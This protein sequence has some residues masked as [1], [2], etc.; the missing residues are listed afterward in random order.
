MK[1]L[2]AT[3]LT[4]AML[5][6]AMAGVRVVDGDTVEIDGTKI[7][8]LSIDTPET[9]RARCENELRLGL[10][11][12]ERLTELLASGEISYTPDGLDRFGRTLATVYVGEVNV[13]DVL[14]KEG[15][16]LPYIPGPEAKA[17]RM[18]TWC[19]SQS[20]WDERPARSGRGPN[21]RDEQDIPRH[22]MSCFGNGPCEADLS[23]FHWPSDH[24]PPP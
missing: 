20:G 8:I 7:R 17:K 12:K 2:L 10:K 24:D 4:F 6:P 21:A 11:A 18:T 14:L 13:A 19:P 9:F 15:H 1:R 3:A 5:T 23:K 22:G 16:A